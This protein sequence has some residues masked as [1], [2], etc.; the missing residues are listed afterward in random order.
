MTRYVKCQFCNSTEEYSTR[1]DKM[2]VVTKVSE[3]TGKSKNF[4]YHKGECY[5]RHTKKEKFIL[6][7]LT[8]KDELNDVLK[9]IYNIK[10]QVPSRIWEILQDL[11]NGTNRYQ[12]FFKKRYK[13][14]V[15]YDVIAESYR[16]SKDSIHW[17]KLNRRFKTLEVEMKYGIAIM[18]N[19]IEDAHK[20]IKNTEQVKKASEGKVERE[21][22]D[23]IE[24][25]DVVFKKKSVDD[26]SSILGDD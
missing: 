10:F 11:R 26:L 21:I 23:I 25:R 24:N 6:D 13:E 4:Y 15:P 19:K 3:T 12:K 20:K 9:D 7:E 17:A 2:E 1:F 22:S 18:Q 5:E 16:M 14:G 8:K